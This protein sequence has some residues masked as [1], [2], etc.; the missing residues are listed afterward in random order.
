[1]GVCGEADEVRNLVVGARLHHALRQHEGG[2]GQVR[3]VCQHCGGERLTGERLDLDG[4]E[5]RDGR[6]VLVDLE[7]ALGDRGVK[8]VAVVDALQPAGRE[9]LRAQSAGLLDDPVAGGVLACG[10]DLLHPV[11]EVRTRGG[12]AAHGRR[13]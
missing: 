6:D 12:G 10:Y 4:F 9:V 1:T 5:A 8:L 2:C 7:A 3:A 11:D 13:V